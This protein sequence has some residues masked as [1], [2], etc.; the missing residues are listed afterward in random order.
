MLMPMAITIVSFCSIDI[1]FYDGDTNLIFY[2]S[3]LRA[4]NT[5]SMTLK[6]HKKISKPLYHH[7]INQI[8]IN[9]CVCLN[10]VIEDRRDKYTTN[11]LQKCISIF[12]VINSIKFTFIRI[13]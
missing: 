7:R 3:P 13:N 6:N 1:V 11:D 5:H 9:Y 4:L 2:Y 12:N 10:I 8:S